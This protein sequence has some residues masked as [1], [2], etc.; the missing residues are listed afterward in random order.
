VAPSTQA[1]AAFRALFD[2]HYGYVT[3]SLR[4]LGVRVADV[5]DVAQEVFLT[6]HQR[7]AEFDTG[8]AVRPWLFGIAYRRALR[9]RSLV[10]HFRE[11]FADADAAPD[12]APAAD[13]QIAN[14]EAR[15]LVLEAIERLEIHRRAVFILHEIDE[16]PMPIVAAT[17]DLPLNTAY[18]RLRLAR[19]D[20]ARAAARLAKAH[21]GMRFAPSGAP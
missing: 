19:E 3:S 18:S 2:A 15:A 5:H 1:D 11:L 9:H 10:R 16:T 7:L 13:E 20:F 8:R 6:V 4:R 14:H 17:L 12:M 21:G